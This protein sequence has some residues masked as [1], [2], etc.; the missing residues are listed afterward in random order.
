MLRLVRR[1]YEMIPKRIDPRARR[2]FRLAI[3]YYLKK[4]NR[5]RLYRIRRFT[6]E[7][8]N[9]KKC[10]IVDWVFRFTTSNFYFVKHYI[11]RDIYLFL[12]PP[13]YESISSATTRRVI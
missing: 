13:S 8:C 3:Y 12:S 2:Y 4:K 7:K 9:R 1:V 5:M 11:T 10:F 6:Y